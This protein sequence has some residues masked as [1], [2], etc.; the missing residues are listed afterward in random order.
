M[1]EFF[2]LTVYCKN[3]F[4]KNCRVDLSEIVEISKAATFD[5]LKN[6]RMRQ[7]LITGT[8]KL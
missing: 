1:A 2:E 3:K 4:F 7:V 6:L 8:K 5:I